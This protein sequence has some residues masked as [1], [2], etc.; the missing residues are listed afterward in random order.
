M[1]SIPTILYVDC[2]PGEGIWRRRLE[3]IR[4]YAATRGWRVETLEHGVATPDTLHEVL[5]TLRPVGCVAECWDSD[6]P[7]SPA[8]FGNVPV[9]FFCPLDEPGWRGAPGV[10]C[11]EAAVARMAFRELSSGNP[12]AYAVVSENGD[13]PWVRERIDA[14]RACCLDAGLECPVSIF[15]ARTDNEISSNCKLMAEWA[16]ALPHRCAVFATTDDCAHAAARAM[17]AVGRTFPHTVTL[18]GADGTEPMPLNREIA[19]AVSTILLD[20]E[21][22]GYL[23]AKALGAFAANEWL[24]CAQN[25]LPPSAAP[26]LVFPPLLVERRKST[27]GHGRREP[28]ILEAMEMIRRE[29]CDGLTAE[30]LAKRFPGTRRLFEI[31]FREAAGHSVLDEILNVRMARAMELLAHTDMAIAAVAHF[32]GFG[33]EG[34]FWKTFRKR[35]G[36]SPLGFRKARE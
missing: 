25:E 17:A 7:L 35:T 12:P 5:D 32:C 22:A 29:A 3:G 4:R 14:F 36:T 33:N 15:P 6:R 20:H 2:R 11:D 13:R 27:R 19:P 34:S 18:V 10:E 16:A 28:R 9:V 8:C 31:R 30:A 26:S 23:A 21:L 1:K 24:R